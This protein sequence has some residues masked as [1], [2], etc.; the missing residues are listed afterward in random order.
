MLVGLSIWFLWYLIRAP[1]EIKLEKIEGLKQQ[2][3]EQ[4]AETGEL[5]DKQQEEIGKLKE[6]IEELRVEPA[7]TVGNKQDI[8]EAR[9]II[10]GGTEKLL[11]QSPFT[12]HTRNI[13]NKI[14]RLEWLFIGTELHQHFRALRQ[15]CFITIEY[16][17]RYASQEDREKYR[18][19]ISE[20]R[21]IILGVLD[22]DIAK[23]S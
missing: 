11:N 13:G 10:A 16:E 3:E 4:Q 21:E 12:E 6:E 2:T 17:K 15:G 5:V 18:R 23:K 22:D 20:N 19:L 7:I 1:L 14:D 9:K 8:I